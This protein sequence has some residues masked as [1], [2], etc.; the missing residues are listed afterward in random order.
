MIV[1]DYPLCNCWVCVGVCVCIMS[2]VG[3]EKLDM[4]SAF[5]EFMT[6]GGKIIVLCV[7]VFTFL[8]KSWDDRKF[9]SEWEQSLH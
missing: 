7:L 9:W 8:D 6:L 2:E 4:K 3:Y 1:P 5:T